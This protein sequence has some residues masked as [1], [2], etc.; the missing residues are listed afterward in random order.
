MKE[1]NGERYTQFLRKRHSLNIAQTVDYNCAY[2][3]YT[4]RQRVGYIERWTFAQ[5]CFLPFHVCLRVF[6]ARYAAYECMFNKSQTK[7]SYKTSFAYFFR[8]FSS[9]AHISHVL[10]VYMHTHRYTN[11]VWLK[12][13]DEVYANWNT[14]KCESL[15]AC[16][17]HIR[18]TLDTCVKRR[19]S[20]LA[21]LLIF[22]THDTTHLS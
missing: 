7:Q 6:A 19:S 9:G 5:I 13:A 3:I 10:A 12:R 11:I 4:L 21:I 22:G 16:T 20:L 18:L 17:K 8:L 1:E 15:R 2:S 14:T